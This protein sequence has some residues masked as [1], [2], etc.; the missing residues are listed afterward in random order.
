M[1]RSLAAFNSFGLLTLSAAVAGG[2][3][4]YGCSGCTGTSDTD[5][6]P[7]GEHNGKRSV[8]RQPPG[9][10]WPKPAFA[11][12]ISGQQKGYLEPCG[13]SAE[14]QVGGMAHRADLM[15]QLREDRKWNVAGLELGD[16]ILRTR[17]Q[18]RLKLQQVLK[19]L[20][21]LNYSAVGMGTR[22][23]ALARDN[24]DWL[25]SLPNFLADSKTGNPPFVAANVTVFDLAPRRWKTQAI[26]GRKLAVTA[27]FGDSYRRRI[28][29][30]GANTSVKISDPKT[31]LPP[32]LAKMKAAKPDLLVLL[33][34][35]DIES[36]TKQLAEQF[37][38][39]DLI[40]SAGGSENGSEQPQRV[41]KTMII[42]VGKKGKYVGLVGVYPDAEENRLRFELVELDTYRFKDDPRMHELM[43]DYQQLIQDNVHA[44]FQ[45]VG[46][47]PHHSG[48]EYVGVESCK[49]C[50]KSA[51]AVW[52]KSKHAHAYK[53]LSIGRPGMKENWI[54]R[55]FDPECLTCHVTG[56]NPQE[57]TR[58][59]S[60]FQVKPLA[61][62]AGKPE[63]YTKL[64][65]QQCENC[66][67]P[68]SQHVELETKWKADPDSVD[69]GQLRQ[70]RRDMKRTLEWADSRNGC[71]RCHDLDNSPNFK[72]KE[73]WPK[74]KHTKD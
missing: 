15:R 12:V 11:L 53:S 7:D 46:D 1:P 47:V 48:A 10:D 57:V 50:H 44:V 39:F 60:G 18:D 21:Q 17:E 28:L 5:K 55:N 27:V 14:N 73:Y 26:N 61:D 45:D 9:K 22:E 19:G 31:A 58:Y 43:R 65:G 59:R 25:I 67:G 33:A 49:D 32:V 13:C 16:L 38:D 69:D 52:S 36:E 34:F 24:P 4:L 42:H 23:V 41:G 20:D 51:Y 40:V 71:Y 2:L 70:S 64:Q 3:F 68:G 56:W 72:F 66:H 29:S 54:P 63:L 37:P 74:I 6:T 35:T 8:K 30:E 62:A